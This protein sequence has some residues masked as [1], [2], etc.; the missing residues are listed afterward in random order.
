MVLAG[1]RPP[2]LG[3]GD[4]ARLRQA[5]QLAMGLATEPLASLLEEASERVLDVMIQALAAR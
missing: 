4:A 3:A 5:L 2:I 1:G